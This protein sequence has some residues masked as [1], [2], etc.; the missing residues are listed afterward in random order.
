M[1]DEHDGE[2]QA[3]EMGRAAR[4]QRQRED[5]L[6]LVQRLEDEHLAR[7]GAAPLFVNPAQLHRIM[8][9]RE[10][11]AR[12]LG[13]PAGSSATRITAVCVSLSLTSCLLLAFFSLF[14]VHACV[15]VHTQGDTQGPQQKYRFETRHRAAA[16]RQRDASGRFLRGESTP[17]VAPSQ[18][19]SV[20]PQPPPQQT[21]T[22]TTTCAVSFVCSPK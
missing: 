6:R 12:M 5:V 10:A 17:A 21:P 2:G 8:R 11:R 9:R 3:R 1:P 19:N 7:A 20:A 18:E 4:A 14:F 13:L 15:C 16:K 22:T